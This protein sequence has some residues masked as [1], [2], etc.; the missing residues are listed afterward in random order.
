[1]RSLTLEEDVV[2]QDET[3][4]FLEESILPANEQNYKAFQSLCSLL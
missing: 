3:Q 4:S 2:T 1:M